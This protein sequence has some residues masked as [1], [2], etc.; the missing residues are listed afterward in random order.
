MSYLFHVA[1]RCR[2]PLHF[3]YWGLIFALAIPVCAAADKSL[4]TPEA[5]AQLELRAAHANPREQCFLYAELVHSMTEEASQQ[6]ATGE[7]AE[8]ATTL[9]RVNQFAHLIH[10]NLA[11][12][13]KRLKYAQMLLHNTAYRLGQVLH[14][15]DNEDQATV[16][17]TL[18]QLHQVNDE[19]LTQ[20]F[21]H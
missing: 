4:P 14:L 21:S 12:D 3:V 11:R 2:I 5:L 6:I 8:A 15:V 20:V 1:L 18:K 7:T 16:Q 13:T 10:V 9:K 19:V 17:D